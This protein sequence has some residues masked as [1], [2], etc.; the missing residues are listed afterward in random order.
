MYIHKCE[1]VIFVYI[2]TSKVCSGNARIDKIY[3]YNSPPL[4]DIKTWKFKLIQSIYSVKCD[5]NSRFKG[6]HSAFLSQLLC[7]AS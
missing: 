3:Q 4:K 1:C 5:T 6:G 7:H 2:M